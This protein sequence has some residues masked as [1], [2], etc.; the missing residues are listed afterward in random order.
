MRVLVP[1][2]GLA[3]LAYEVVKRGKPVAIVGLKI[4][5]GFNEMTGY[6]CQG[7][8]FSHYMLLSSFFILNR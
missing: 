5:L 3:R 4:K 7:N 6:S 8:E 2:T 1:G